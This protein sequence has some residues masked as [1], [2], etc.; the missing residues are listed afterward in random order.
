MHGRVDQD[1]P[2]THLSPGVT[3]WF[4]S[5]ISQVRENQ[6]DH[7]GSALPSLTRGQIGGAALQAANTGDDSRQNPSTMDG[8]RGAL[9]S[10][11]A[12]FR[13]RAREIKCS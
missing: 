6:E 11:A 4:P 13:L 12:G 7:T 8:A 10:L 5:G 1:I 2:S 9:V 3:P